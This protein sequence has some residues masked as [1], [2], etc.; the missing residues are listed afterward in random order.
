MSSPF[1]KISIVS[2]DFHRAMV[3]TSAIAY[4]QKKQENYT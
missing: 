4:N 2:P 3:I 1:L